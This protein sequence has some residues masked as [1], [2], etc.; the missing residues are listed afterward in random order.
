LVLAIS[1][2]FRLARFWVII[3]SNPFSIM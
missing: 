1:S 3:T 2:R